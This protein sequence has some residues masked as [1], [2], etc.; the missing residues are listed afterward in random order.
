M[1][2]TYRA[3]GIVTLLAI[4]ALAVQFALAVFTVPGGGRWVSYASITPQ[5]GGSLIVILSIW[6]RLGWSRTLMMLPP[7][8]SAFAVIVAAQSRRWIW[9]IVFLVAGLL[10]SYGP[11]LLTAFFPIFFPHNIVTLAVDVGIV[12]PL[13]PLPLALVFVWLGLR[14]GGQAAG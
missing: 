3:L 6:W 5:Q 8:V 13:I 7:L 1:V 11:L 9:L 10:A 4:V 12:S 2:R 14:R